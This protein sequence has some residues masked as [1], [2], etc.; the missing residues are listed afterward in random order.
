MCPENTETIDTLGIRLETSASIRSRTS[1]P[2]TP[3][4]KHLPPLKNPSPRANMTGDTP[5]WDPH[6][7]ET[8]EG[9]FSSV[10][11]P[12]IAR[13]GAFFSINFIKLYKICIP[14]HRS[15]F[16]NFAKFCQNFCAFFL[17]FVKFCY[18]PTEIR[19]FSN[20]LNDFD[21]NLSEIFTKL[22]QK[23]A[24]FRETANFE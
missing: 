1:R 23:I 19:R 18:F 13:V 16:R 3:R 20:G 17:K 7:I 21:E 12:L 11:T 8:L 5:V 22:Q 4:C 14:S 2:K 24:R 15:K 10:S 9:S 6:F